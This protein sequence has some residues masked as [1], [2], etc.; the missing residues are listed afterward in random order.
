MRDEIARGHRAADAARAVKADSPRNTNPLVREFVV[1]AHRLE[2]LEIAAVLNRSRS[3]L[4][5]D[6]TIDEVLLPGM[7]TIGRWWE[8]GRCDV[9]HEHVATEACNG[10]LAGT[11]NAAPPPW[12]PTSIVLACGPRDLH[13]IGLQAMGVLLT[14]RGWSCRMLSAR[15]PAES[16]SLVQHQTG[17]GGVIVV[18]HLSSARRAAVEALRVV[19]ASGVELFFAGNAFVSRQSRIG[20]P[21]T[22]LSTNLAEAAELVTTTMLG[23]IHS[24]R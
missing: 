6:R 18:S 21:G 3:S 8:T 23:S 15:V 13:T 16:L 2:P 5:L 17:A 4:G 19:G 24:G 7:R 11:T 12:Q 1:A 9:A 14:H 22:Y 20:V 10:W